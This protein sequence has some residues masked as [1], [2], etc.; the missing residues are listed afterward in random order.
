MLTQKLLGHLPL[1]LHQAPK[2]VGIIG[3]GSG[4]T[5][6]AVLQCGVARQVLEISAVVKASASSLPR[7]ALP[8]RPA[9]PLIVGDGRTHLASPRATTT[10]LSGTLEPWMAG[11]AGLFRAILQHRPG[12]PASRRPLLPVGR[13]DMSDADCGPSPPRSSPCSRTP[14][15]ERESDVLLVGGD[16]A[17]EPIAGARR[18]FLRSAREDGSRARR[19]SRPSLLSSASRPRKP[20]AL[21]RGPHTDRRSPGARTHRAAGIVL[22]RGADEPRTAGT[23]REVRARPSCGR[24]SPMGPPRTGGTGAGAR[25]R[26][27]GPGVRATGA[28]PSAARATRPFWTAWSERGW[29]GRDERNRERSACLG[30][31]RPSQCP[32]PRP[33]PAE[34]SDRRDGRGHG[35]RAA[36]RAGARRAGRSTSRPRSSP[37]TVTCVHSGVCGKCRRSFRTRRARTTTRR[38]P[39]SWPAIEGRARHRRRFRGSG[40]RRAGQF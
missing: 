16:H 23:R 18:P 36:G 33:V 34:C 7:T 38:P 6:G 13:N 24:R 27:Q 40:P 20:E 22:E 19:G 11:M 3:L 1:L 10:W 2:R 12:A 29:C 14:A 30:V 39:D 8:E 15:A 4:V 17:I 9:D 37:T 35:A 21:C 32:P 5:L 28:R 31:V 25:R 26:T